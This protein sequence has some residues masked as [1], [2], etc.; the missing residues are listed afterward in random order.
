MTRPTDTK[1][2]SARSPFAGCAILVAALLV[3]TFLVVF[4]TVTL[5]RQ[6]NEIA[7]FTSE[8]PAPVEN[9]SLD[10]QEANLNKLAIKLEEFRLG[11]DGKEESLLTLTTEELN[12]AIA[13]Y[14]AFKDLRGTFRVLSIDDEAMKIAISFPLNGKPRLARD[15]ESGWVTSDLR[16]LNAELTARPGLLKRE[17]VLQ[18]NAINV[19]GSTVPREFTEQMSP[20]R[21]TERYLT[22]PVI[23]SVMA[24]LTSVSLTDGALVLARTP[25]ELPSDLITDS[26]VDSASRRLFLFFGIGASIFLIFTGIIIFIGLRAKKNRA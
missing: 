10:E 20:Y 17:I 16:H 8:K 18:L 23:G 2:N 22:D 1:D 13:S 19:P 5:F 3:M 24:K 26:Q 12:L 6:F 14:D 25:G 4:S 7:K 15:G 9:T 11:L 21:I